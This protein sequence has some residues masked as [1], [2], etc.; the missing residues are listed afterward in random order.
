MKILAIQKEAPG[1]SA[2][3]FV[4]HLRGEASAGWA[5]YKEGVIREMYFRGDKPEVILIL[6]CENIE[7]AESKL[8]TLP[9][10]QKELISFDL[11]ELK[12]YHGYERLFR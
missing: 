2:R 12:P 10:V 7:E 9:L 4:P 5:L 8:A 3:D 11:I 1:L 6:E